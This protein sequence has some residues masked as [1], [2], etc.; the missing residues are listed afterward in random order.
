[1]WLLSLKGS[2]HMSL[3]L[4]GFSSILL[5]GKC[6]LWLPHQLK[7][8]R[9]RPQHRDNGRKS[10]SNWLSEYLLEQSCCSNSELPLHGFLVQRK[11][12]LYSV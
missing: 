2:W 1:M 5:L 11:R 7:T 12:N 8:I 10:Y 4:L 3:C 6:M 9:E